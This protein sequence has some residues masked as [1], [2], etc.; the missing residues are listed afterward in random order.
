[1][2]AMLIT[3]LTLNSNTNFDPFLWH[4][5]ILAFYILFILEI[6]VVILTLMFYL[7]YCELFVQ[8]KFILKNTCI[9][10]S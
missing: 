3:H 4:L 10:S 7:K 8:R 5:T 2:L 6:K 9:Y 1:M